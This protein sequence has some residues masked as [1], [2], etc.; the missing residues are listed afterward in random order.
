MSVRKCP[1][2]KNM[3]ADDTVICPICGCNPKGR[4]AWRVVMLM[5]TGLLAGWGAHH[6]WIGRAHPS[7][8]G[9]PAI[10]VQHLAG[11]VRTA[12]SQK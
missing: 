11:D 10:Q 8:N 1:A 9:S 2:C 4:I 3:I 6:L 5:I 12:S 7:G